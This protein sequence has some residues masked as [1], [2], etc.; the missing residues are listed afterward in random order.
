MFIVTIY[1][2]NNKTY[3]IDDINWE[4]NPKSK[5][6]G[7]DGSE[8]IFVEYY[9]KVYEKKITDM[10]QPLLVSRPKKSQV[11]YNIIH[12]PCIGISCDVKISVSNVKGLL[13]HYC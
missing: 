12:V 8:Q 10:D 7:R 9:A 4:M 2:Y 5:F 13:G 1:R 6:K 3:R 11:R